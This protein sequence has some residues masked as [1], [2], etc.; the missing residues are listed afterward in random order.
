MS[1]ILLSPS[2]VGQR[3][4]SQMQAKRLSLNLTQKALSDRSAVSFGVVKKFER[5]G[6]ISLESLLKLA[7][8]LNSLDAFQELFKE[9][10]PER[11]STLDELLSNK[12]RKRARQ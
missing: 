8:T 7:V 11:A 6:K 4:A 12:T 1:F 10:A 9:N 2:E 5:S 3:I